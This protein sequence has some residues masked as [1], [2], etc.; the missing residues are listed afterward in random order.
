MP[1]RR[2][3]RGSVAVSAALLLGAGLVG[4]AAAPA[5]AAPGALPEGDTIFAVDCE[6]NDGQVWE[7]DPLTAVLTPIGTGSLDLLTSCA[8]PSAYDP[9]TGD[10]YWISWG[11]EGRSDALMLLDIETGDSVAVAPFTEDGTGDPVAAASIAIGADGAAYL[12]GGTEGY[13][14]ILYSL[15]L[16]TAIVT[17]IGD[18]G[19]VDQWWSFAFNPA[20][21]EFYGFD[22][23]AGGGF[24]LIDVETGTATLILADTEI[25]LDVYGIAF[26]AEGALWGFGEGAASEGAWVLFSTSVDDFAGDLL[27]VGTP[28]EDEVEYFSESI[29]IVTSQPEPEPAALAATG[30]EDP[31]VAA[32]AAMGLVG[33]G[34]AFLLLAGRRRPGMSRSV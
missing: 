6:D 26:D 29:F 24:S 2:P 8:G 28:E 13:D 34:V 12:I 11:E 4:L 23:A 16:S 7:V 33:L 1:A 19:G 5:S 3:P 10:A 31:I 30:A 21:G 32:G 17:E 20:D 18:I 25:P 9:T 14:S 27:V 15:D 22:A